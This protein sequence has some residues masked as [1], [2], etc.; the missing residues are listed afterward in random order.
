MGKPHDQSNRRLAQAE[1]ACRHSAALCYM[2]VILKTSLGDIDIE[3]WP[4]EAPKVRWQRELGWMMSAVLI[5]G[6]LVPINE[7]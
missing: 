1:D 2:Q 4:K 5:Y 6:L 7:H 3:L